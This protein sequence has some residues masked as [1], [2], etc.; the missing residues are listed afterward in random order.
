MLEEIKVADNARLTFHVREVLEGKRKFENAAQGVSRMI[1]EKE[2]KKISRGGKTVFDFEFFRE[3]NKHIIGWYEEIND[4]VHF[5]KSAAEGGSA[6]EMAFVLVGEPGNGKTFFVDYICEKYRHFLTRPENRKYTFKFVGLDKA[7]DYNEKVAEMHSMTFEDPIILA[8]NLFEDPNE[9]KEYLAKAGFKDNA[10]ED[11]YGKR[12]PLGAST[13]Y[14][15][16]ALLERFGGDVNKALEHVEVV[17]VPMRESL[18]TTTGKYSAKDKITSSSVDLLGEES[19]QHLLLLRLGDPNKFDLRRGA[20]ARVAGAGVHFS[21]ELFKNKKDL[22]QIYLQVIQN[23]T[24][25]LDGFIWPIDTLIIATSNNW[26]YNRFV[27]EKEESPIKDRCRLCYVAHNTDYKLQLQLTSYSI[28]SQGRTTIMGKPMHEDPNLNYATSVG[29]VLTRLINSEKLNPVET[30]KLEAGEV[31]GEKGVKTLSEVKE[32]ANANPD[33]TARWGQKGLGHRD[34]G[35]VLQILGATPESNEGKCTFALDVFKAMDRVILDYVT[36]ATDREK[37]KKDL[38]IAR[39]LYREKVKTSIFN[40]YRDDKD[41]VR[42]DVMNYVNMV[43]G[44]DADNL[45]PD[46]MWGY[47]DPQ[48]GERVTI[49]IDQKYIDSVESRLG[50][51]TNERKE[52]FRN[53][54]RKTYG[55]KLSEHP[56]YD[57][58]DNQELVKAVTDVRLESD[59]AGA[60]SLLGALANQTNEENVAIHNRMVDTMLGKLCYCV[61]CA[62]KTIEYFCEKQDES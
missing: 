46:K 12:R 11:L 57:F 58:T 37:Y 1:L 28:G 6:K 50:L 56:N 15:W 48:T 24:I 29:V 8:M 42:K 4:F 55:Q 10:V 51:S 9:S 38:A 43:I 5:V 62:Q 60:G 27:S 47:T 32:V 59:V 35:R 49:K 41:A 36:E 2:I 40:A 52:S 14:L 13:E 22:V 53:T 54:I 20:L 16:Y 21:D 26:E 17:P 19:L 34:L 33:V 3:G 30:M 44:S 31:A 39:K 23:R 25:E 7:L 61:T 45:G 18:G